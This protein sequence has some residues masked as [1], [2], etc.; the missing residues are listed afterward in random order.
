MYVSS[1]KLLTNIGSG[2]TH[3]FWVSYIY[4]SPL[5]PGYLLIGN[6]KGCVGDVEGGTV[7][8][9]LLTNEGRHAR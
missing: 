7:G 9:P 3:N 4:L 1:N 6:T 2:E 8:P 5:Y